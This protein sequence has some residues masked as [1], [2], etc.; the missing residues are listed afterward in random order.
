MHL[1]EI[2]D[3]IGLVIAKEEGQKQEDQQEE[4]QK[5][6]VQQEE[7]QKQEGQHEEGLSQEEIQK[8]NIKRIRGKFFI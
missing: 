3:T 2:Q 5:R 8:V 6:E 1:K 4:G 7:G